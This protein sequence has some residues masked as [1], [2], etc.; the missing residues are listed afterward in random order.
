MR[1][2][3]ITPAPPGSLYGNRVTAN[4]WARIL[5]GLGHR[6]FIAQTYSGQPADLLI[7]LHA[8]RSAK[9]IHDYRRRHPHNPLIVALTGTDLY[10]DLDRNEKAQR[11]LDCA[12]LIVALQ[13]RALDRLPSKWRKKTRIVNQSVAAS[14]RKGSRVSPRRFD[15]CV[16]G[17]LRPVKDPFRAAMA[18]R[19]LPASSRIRVVH[20]GGA[21]NRTQR[22]RALREMASNQRYHWLGELPRAQVHGV[23][24]RSTLFVISSRAEGGA[25]ALGE[26]IAAGLPVLASRIPGSVGIIGDDYPGYFEVGDTRQLSRLMSRCEAEPRFLA[27]LQARCQGVAEL[28]DPS[29][30]EAAWAALLTE[31]ASPALDP[32]KGEAAEAI[33]G[34][35]RFK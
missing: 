5:R 13:E 20:A 22:E 4:R 12:T 18:A 19:L 17:R 2:G 3:I 24:S 23:L 16:I 28:F 34:D 32:K 14:K 26:A 27:D 31:A 21:I 10:G 11:S 35:A 7:A 6:V 33:H 1:I 9:S 29:R 30:E 15:V 8:R 25:N